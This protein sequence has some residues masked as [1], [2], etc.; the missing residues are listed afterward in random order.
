MKSVVYI[1][2]IVVLVGFLHAGLFAQGKEIATADGHFS[3]TLPEGFS[4]PEFS[5]QFVQTAAGDIPMQLYTSTSKNNEVFLISYNDYPDTIFTAE[6]LSKMLDNVRDGAI[7]KMKAEMERQMDFTFEGNL[8]RT[9]NF[10]LKIDNKESYGRMDFM[11]VVPRLYQIIY[12]GTTK[13]DR[14]SKAIKDAFRSFHTLTEDT[15]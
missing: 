1:F 11:I 7:E 13:K 12:I 2:S 10:K 9:V 5:R 6:N 3:V 4:N 8:A 15:R 14:D